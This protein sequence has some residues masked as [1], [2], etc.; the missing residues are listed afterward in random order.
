MEENP[1]WTT[2]VW[3]KHDEKGWIALWE[4]TTPDR[5]T[6]GADVW[7]A[8]QGFAKDE[9][10]IAG[11]HFINNQGTKLVEEINLENGYMY[12]SWAA[13]DGKVYLVVLDVK[14]EDVTVDIPLKAADGND[15]GSYTAKFIAGRANASDITGTGNMNITLSGVEALL[16]EINAN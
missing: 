15:M 10:A 3:D 1:D 12:Y 7:A 2:H 13:A 11:A 9:Q 8:L 5:P 16:F 4:V 14:G 6:A